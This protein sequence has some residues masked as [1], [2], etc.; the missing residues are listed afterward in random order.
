MFYN[1][2]KLRFIEVTQAYETVDDESIIGP[3]FDGNQ[4]ALMDGLRDLLRKE[5]EAKSTYVEDLLHYCT[6]QAF[7]PDLEV[8][9]NFRVTIEFSHVGE[10]KDKDALPACHTC[11]KIFKLPASAYG[12]SIE[13]FKEKLQKALEHSEKNG[14]NMM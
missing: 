8:H 6:G 7:V 9:P 11:E 13:I 1:D 5:I 4:I 10:M 3:T 2:G 14:F 12:G